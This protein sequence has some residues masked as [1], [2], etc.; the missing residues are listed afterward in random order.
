MKSIRVFMLN[1]PISVYIV[2]NQIK[3]LLTR[4]RWYWLRFLN[5]VISVK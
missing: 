4:K 2:R 1:V 5:K 3:I